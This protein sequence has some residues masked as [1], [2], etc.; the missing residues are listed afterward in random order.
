MRATTAKRPW[1]K[2]VLHLSDCAGVCGGAAEPDAAVF[3]RMVSK[4]C[5][6]T[7]H[8]TDSRRTASCLKASPSSPTS[9]AGFKTKFR[10]KVFNPSSDFA[11]LQLVVASEESEMALTSPEL[12]LAS[13]GELLFSPMPTRPTSNSPCGMLPD[14]EGGAQL[15][16]LTSVAELV[17]WCVDLDL[18]YCCAQVFRWTSWDPPTPV[19]LR[20]SN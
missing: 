13:Q 9:R 8:Y 4:P 15:V 5:W 20:S 2:T 1:P 19:K 6:K 3:V 18:R 16:E 14:E 11:S 10:I 17:R 7:T 12:T